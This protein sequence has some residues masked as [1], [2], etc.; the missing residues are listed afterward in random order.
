MLGE[1]R[2]EETIPC[3]WL[4]LSPV[5]LVYVGLSVCI[6]VGWVLVTETEQDMARNSEFRH[7][8]AD[9]TYTSRGGVT[10]SPLGGETRR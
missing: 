7:V 2:K 4:G 6:H 3:Y 1:T 10:F 9:S 8:K 5:C